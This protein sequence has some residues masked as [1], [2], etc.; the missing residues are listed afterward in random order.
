MT[1]DQYQ[2]SRGMPPP[3]QPGQDGQ[4]FPPP[5]A[6]AYGDDENYHQDNNA[7]RFTGVGV[8]GAFDG[9]ASQGGAYN[10][11]QQVRTIGFII[12]TKQ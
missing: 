6:H 3:S 5:P 8:D 4:Y 7:P 11:A 2:Q 10:Y 9:Q 1:R 12:T